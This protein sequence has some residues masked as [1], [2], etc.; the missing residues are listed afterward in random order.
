[1]NCPYKPIPIEVTKSANV[2]K[3]NTLHQFDTVGVVGVQLPVG[4]V[5]IVFYIK[6]T[7]TT[8]RRGLLY[9]DD[10]DTVCWMYPEDKHAEWCKQPYRMKYD[11]LEHWDNGVESGLKRNHGFF[12]LWVSVLRKWYNGHVMYRPRLKIQGCGLRAGG[13]PTESNTVTVEEKPKPAK[14]PKPRKQIIK[15]GCNCRKG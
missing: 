8:S 5:P 10:R 6:E 9:Y 2:D 15:H 1:M 3:T 13:Y 11:G 7:P 14:L 4:K 12:D